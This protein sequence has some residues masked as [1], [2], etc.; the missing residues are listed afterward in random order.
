[1]AYE[2]SLSSQMLGEA[3]LILFPRS[4]IYEV[5]FST[6]FFENFIRQL[7]YFQG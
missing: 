1:M 5:V 4:E 7:R 3:C 2:H 6:F